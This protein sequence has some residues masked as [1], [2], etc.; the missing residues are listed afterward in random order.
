MLIEPANKRAVAFIDGQNLYFACRDAFGSKEPDY[1]VLKLSKLICQRQGW[2]HVQTRFYTGVPDRADNVRLNA[3]WT[4]KK[5]SMSRNGVVVYSRPLRYRDKNVTLPGGVVHTVR[6]AEEKGIDVRIAIDIIRLAHRGDYDVA[7]VF[8]QDQDLS[9]V[10]DEI[11]VIALEQ[12]RWIRIASAFPIGPSY[13]NARGINQTEW[14]EFDH[15][16][17]SVCVDPYN[18]WPKP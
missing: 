18:H 6:V 7:L 15:A 11:R 9:E 16:E 1:D 3:F 2:D 5:R 10:A 8:S 12:T 17:Y 14:V 4:S 13:A